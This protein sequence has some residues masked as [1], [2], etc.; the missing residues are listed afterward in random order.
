MA[1]ALCNCENAIKLLLEYG[2][3]INLKNKN[4]LT[5]L[6][7]AAYCG[8]EKALNTCLMTLHHLYS[9]LLGVIGAAEL[10]LWQRMQQHNNFEA[11]YL[12]PYFR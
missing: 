2:A 6:M 4:G 3:N 10:A 12:L 11:L 1:T 7:L 5:A 9:S 8:Y